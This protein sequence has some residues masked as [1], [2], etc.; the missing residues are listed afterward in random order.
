M[1]IH[2]LSLTCT[3]LLLRSRRKAYKFF[4]PIRNTLH[5][6]N[7]LATTRHCST[8]PSAIRAG[9]PILIYDRHTSEPSHVAYQT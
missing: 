2:T 6:Y 9:H 1:Q 4:I 8:T 5:Y 7:N 3:P